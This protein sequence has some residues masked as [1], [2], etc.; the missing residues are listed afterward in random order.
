MSLKA[1]S[2]L[3]GRYLSQVDDLADYLSE[4]ALARYRVQVE[5]EWLIL[6]AERSEIAHVRPFTEAEQQLLR[7]WIAEFDEQQARR[8]LQIEQTTRH[9]VKAVEYYLKE[10]LRDTSLADIRESVHFCC[11]SEDIS[12]LAYALM[13]KHGIQQSWLPPAR[14]LVDEV[15]ALAEATRSTPLLSRTHGQPATPSTLGKELAVTVYRWQRQ[16]KQLDRAEY[17]GKFNGAV[18]SYSAHTAAYPNAPWEKISRVLVER[19]GLGFNPLTTQIDPHDYMAELFHLLIRFNTITLDFVRDMW[20]YISLGCFRQQVVGHQVGSST[21]PHKVNPIN[22]ENA[23]ANL[24]VSSALLCHLA[25]KLP[26]S[27]LQRDLSD[28]SALRNIGTALGHSAVAIQS[29]RN[30][31]ANV[32]V[33]ARALQ[34]DLEESWEILG[35][36]VQTVMR[37]AGH[38]N[39]YEQMKELTRGTAVTREDMQTFIRHLDLPEA[40][41]NR[42]L[43]LTP[44][45]YTGLAGHLVDHINSNQGGET[46]Q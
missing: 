26:V 34:S 30:G 13:L 8:I 9:D 32:E 10:R 45:T 44:H 12:N 36:A 27:R 5:V 42:L 16:L 38:E 4:Y 29:A 37:K 46:I 31:L 23:E 1:L 28:T 14:R 18:G 19:L 21:M 24:G 40:D 22:F 39:P 25:V 7:S 43:T 35:E 2:P 15:A 20:T 3:D 17:L 6:M 11:T 41:R 33:D